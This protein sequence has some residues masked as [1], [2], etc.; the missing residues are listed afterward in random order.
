LPERMSV[1]SQKEMLLRESEERSHELVRAAPVAMLV[2]RGP[3]ETVE[4]ANDKFVKLFGYTQEDIP[5]VE[6]WWPLAYPDKQYRTEVRAAWQERIEKALRTS[7]DIESMEGRVRCKDG[8]T[9]YIEF[10]LSMLGDAF[11][12]SFVD[13]TARKMAEEALRSSEE[14]FRLAAEAGRMY[15]CEW[16]AATDMVTRSAECKILLGSGAA[17][18]LP[19]SEVRAN[20]HPEDLWQIDAAIESLRPENPTSRVAY[21]AHRA[22]G[23]PVWLEQSFRGRFDE[24][25]KVTSIVGMIADITSRKD[26]ENTLKALSG[27]L[28]EA[29]EQERRR[30]ARDL[31][32]DI[33]Q[34][35]AVLNIELQKLADDPPESRSVLRQIVQELGAKASEISTEVSAITHELH[36]PKLELLGIVAAMRGFCEEMKKHQNFRVDFRQSG[37]PQNLPK[38]ISLCLFRIFQEGVRNAGKHSGLGV[39]EAELAGAPNEIT[40]QIRDQ[41]AGFTSEDAQNS[42]GLGLISMRERVGLVKG[43]IAIESKPLGGTSIHVR[44]PLNG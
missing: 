36:S 12:V 44:I 13:M 37:V 26:A 43:S 35:L 9:K 14:R 1:F 38:A 16:N 8:S 4:V 30:I 39:V 42:P 28:I 22:D 21:R 20:I 32:D 31:H 25:G 41:G 17:L 11:Q 2:S 29:Q 3:Q 40:L 23:S 5:D 10:H 18:R 27:R 15:A 33:N 7:R 34:R 6:H 24:E 19:L